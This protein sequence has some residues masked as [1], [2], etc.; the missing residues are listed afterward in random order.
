[1]KKLNFC[2][3]C[4]K[5]INDSRHKRCRY[6]YLKSIEKK[7]NLCLD[8]GKEIYY[9]AKRCAS[10]WQLGKRNSTWQ[11]GKTINKYYCEDCGKQLKGTYSYKHKKCSKCYINILKQKGNLTPN[12]QGGKSFEIY[13]VGWTKTFKEQIRE[14]DNHQCQICGKLEIEQQRKLDVHHIDYD[15]DNLNQENLITLCHNCHMKT[16]GNRNH[17]K[18]YF[19]NLTNSKEKNY[20]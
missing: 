19:E 10:C 8:C 15:K 7:P 6:C 9:K 17:W 13:P 1:M 3:D 5:E 2:I 14:R 18:N 12:W 16:N 4:G 11:G 20:V